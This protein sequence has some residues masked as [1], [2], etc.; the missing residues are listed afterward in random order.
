MNYKRDLMCAY[1]CECMWVGDEKYEENL[2]IF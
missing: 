2:N 1:A